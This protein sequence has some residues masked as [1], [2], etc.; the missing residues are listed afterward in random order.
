M[1]YSAR[2]PGARVVARGLLYG[3][4]MEGTSNVEH[5]RWMDKITRAL[6]SF[7]VASLRKAEQAQ[8]RRPGEGQDQGTEREH[9]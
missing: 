1:A 9:T 5:D 8:A 4:I 3:G 7:R 6:R 2:F